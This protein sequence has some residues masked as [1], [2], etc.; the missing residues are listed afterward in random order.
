MM[1]HAFQLS[2]FLSLLALGGCG[3]LQKEPLT[4]IGNSQEVGDAATPSGFAISPVE[5]NDIIQRYHGP[6]IFVDEFYHDG[7]N[8][9]VRNAGTLSKAAPSKKRCTVI[10]GQTGEIYN[11]EAD[12]WERVVDSAADG[13]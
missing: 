13:D 5:A 8:Y 9:Y 6:R 3:I 11:R 7:R 2:W 10:N 4:Y 12:R 1:T